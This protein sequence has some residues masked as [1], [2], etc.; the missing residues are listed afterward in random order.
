MEGRDIGTVVAPNADLKIF[1][2]ANVEVRAKR[3]FKQLRSEG[4][5]CRLSDVLELLK[6]RDERDILRKSAPLIAAG[7]AFIIDTS[8]ISPFE[9]IEKIKNFVNL[10]VNRL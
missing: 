3:R 6:N 10:S 7:D 2:T 4:K 5:N 9:V 1:I 8:N